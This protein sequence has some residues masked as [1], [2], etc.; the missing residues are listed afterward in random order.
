MGEEMEGNEDDECLSRLVG[1]GLALLRGM[2]AHGSL[3]LTLPYA[4]RTLLEPHRH[5]RWRH[6]GT[7]LVR[8]RVAR[9]AAAAALPEARGAWRVA[10]IAV[11]WGRR[12][13]SRAADWR[14]TL[15]AAVA[16][17]L[18][19]TGAP[20]RD[21]AAPPLVTEVFSGRGWGETRVTLARDDG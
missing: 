10:A 5:W 7:Q 20:L 4:P 18:R 2:D 12:R 11:D 17:A 19:D 15:S 14:A 1:N 16:E 9:A 6:H 13:P 8:S 3:T 21:D